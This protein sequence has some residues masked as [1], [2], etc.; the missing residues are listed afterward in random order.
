MKAARISL[1]LWIASAA[2]NA[3][4]GGIQ[5]A[6]PN[7]LLVVDDNGKRVLRV[8]LDG[9]AVTVFSPPQGAQTN[10]LTSPS[11]IGTGPDGTIVVAN[12][13]EGT[14]V[15]IDPATGAQFPVA[16]LFSGPPAIGSVPRDVA[17]NPREPAFG[18]LPTLGV[19]AQGALHQVVRSTFDTTGS[20]LAPY[21]SPYDP[22]NARFVAERDPGTS[23]PIDYYV[24]TDSV[25]AILRYDG[26]TGT[27]APFRDYGTVGSIYGLDA[28]ATGPYLLVVSYRG[29][30]CNG[31]G[32]ENGVHLIR[33]GGATDSISSGSYGCPGPVA[34][35]SST[36]LL[37]TVDA[38]GSPQRVVGMDT[39]PFPGTSF[40]VAPLP[41]G[42]SASDMA[43][44]RVPEPAAVALA[45]A[46]LGALA[47]TARA[48]RRRSER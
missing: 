31:Y 24:A 27:V 46:A 34:L 21:P 33:E 42:T 5:P 14:L 44:A 7:A 15:E 4:A 29:E 48:H 40:E 9:S 41:S 38:T 1:L 39:D 35:D 32:I 26:A 20:L 17:V 30:P 45:A 12:F 25:P 3:F 16:G 37:Y 36:G 6:R 47:A 8:A 19:A 23:D 22:Q 11:G 13:V 28:P 10:L 43:L 2:G 18:F